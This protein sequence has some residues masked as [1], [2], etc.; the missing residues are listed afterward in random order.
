MHAYILINV[1]LLELL[2][3][4]YSSIPQQHQAESHVYIDDEGIRMKSRS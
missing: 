2:A 4:N 3:K 1:F